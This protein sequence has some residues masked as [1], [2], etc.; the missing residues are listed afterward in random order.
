MFFVNIALL[1]SLG[2]AYELNF[3]IN[4]AK[5]AV[6][7]SGIAY[8]TG[9]IAGT[10]SVDSWSCKECKN[11]PN[12]NATSFQGST[13]TDAKG[14]VAYDPDANEIVV[15]FSGTDPASIRN[16]IDDI[17]TIKT[18]YPYCDGCRVHEGF[19]RT[20]QSTDAQVKSLLNLYTSTYPAATI[21]VT[22]HSLGAALA[23]H[24]VAELTHVGYTLKASYTFGMP[25]VGDEAFET[26]YKEAMVG[27]YRVTHHKDPVPHLPTYNM[28][29]HHMPYEAFYSQDNYQDIVLCSFE[30]EDPAC[31]NQYEVDVNVLDHLH[32]LGF[33]FTTNYLSANCEL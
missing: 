13:A 17:D 18:D 27:T 9:P 5:R 29:F 26:W 2:F 1:F 24:A 8:C 16:W 30:G 15:S 33:D 10:N 28:G 32:Y 23:A 12:V 19:Y 21:A 20:Y 6:S 4:L 14:F 3:D 7:F 31:S 25:R 22:G 11:Y